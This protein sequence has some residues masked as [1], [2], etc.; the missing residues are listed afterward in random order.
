M[1]KPARY[2]EEQIRSELAKLLSSTVMASGRTRMS[3]SQ[4]AGIHKDALR[5]VLLGERSASLGEASRIFIACG[6]APQSALTLFLLVDSKQASEWAGAEIG[7]FLEGFLTA[8]PVALTC[9]LGEKLHDLKPRWARGTAQRVA[10]LLSD[11][12]DELESRDGLYVEET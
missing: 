9:E 6:V 2:E 3:V 8:L 12:I 4:E 11:H 10:R 7:S 1:V 5:R